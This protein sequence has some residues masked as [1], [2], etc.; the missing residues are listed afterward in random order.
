MNAK[1]AV[2]ASHEMPMLFKVCEKN[3]NFFQKIYGMFLCVSLAWEVFFLTNFIFFSQRR[4]FEKLWF[5][6]EC[7]DWNAFIFF[8]GEQAVECFIPYWVPRNVSINAGQALKA[9]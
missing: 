3:V 8:C 5:Y 2:S 1:N 4:M 7:P 9:A 6:A